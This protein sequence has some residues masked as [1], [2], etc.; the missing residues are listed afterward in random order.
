MKQTTLAITVMCCAS[1]AAAQPTAEQKVF[2]SQRS[3]T[4]AP[5]ASAKQA[6]AANDKKAAA[7]RKQAE[8][9]RAKLKP[10]EEAKLLYDRYVGGDAL[11]ASKLKEAANNGNQWASLYYGVLAH[12][13]RLPGANGPDYVLAQRAYMKAVKNSDNSLTGNYLAAY[14]LGVLYFNGGGAI[15]KDPAAALRWFQTSVV[16]YRE[17]RKNKSAV[18]WPASAY[19]AQIM[20]NGYGTKPDL[21]GARPYWLQAV[22]SNEPVALHGFANT[23]FKENP[24]TAISYYRRAADRWHV[25]SMVVLAR[26]YAHAD[27]YHQADPVQAT[28]WMLRAAHYDSR[29]SQT[30][31]TMMASLNA[32]GQKKAREAAAQWMRLRGIRVAQFDYTSPLNDDPTTIR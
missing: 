1:I 28:S 29:H 6:D 10:R 26:W 22:K 27:K 5:V 20:T 30:S 3:A 16:S 12:K 2:G 14:N 4:S 15:K 18:F 25:P 9:E 8:K 23:I 19:I 7:E 24:F 11:Y 31:A 21:A 17:L 32:E 13:G